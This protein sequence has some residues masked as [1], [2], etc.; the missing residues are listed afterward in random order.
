MAS[1]NIFRLG[2]S[3]SVEMENSKCE[4]VFH[5]L[6]GNE[7]AKI[8]FKNKAF[9]IHSSV[10]GDDKKPI[11]LSILAMKKLVSFLPLFLE[12]LRQVQFELDGKLQ[13][14]AL[15][16]LGGIKST[17]LLPPDRV[18]A[19]KIICFSPPSSKRP[20]YETTLVLSTFE[21]RPYIWLKVFFDVDDKFNPGKL[22][23]CCCKGGAR[24]EQ[25]EMAELDAFANKFF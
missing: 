18:F 1:I 21:T 25:V 4:N 3:K 20:T 10:A 9:Y 24:L 12:Q 2:K 19:K 14:D 13:E 5:Y 6:P 16:H 23:T 11:I 22:I 8:E 7:L 17:S 15:H